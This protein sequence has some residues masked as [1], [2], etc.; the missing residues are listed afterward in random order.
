M[1]GPLVL[2]YMFQHLLANLFF[3][4]YISSKGQT[5][6]ILA[7]RL[8]ASVSALAT[9]NARATSITAKIIIKATAP[10]IANSTSV[11]PF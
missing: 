2:R 6:A 5:T 9:K 7:P 8:V 11:M 4:G 3:I 10:M 1:P